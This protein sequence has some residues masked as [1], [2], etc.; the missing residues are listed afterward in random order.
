MGHFKI[1]HE[2]GPK[3][4]S[5]G[6]HIIWSEKSQEFWGKLNYFDANLIIW[7]QIYV[8]IYTFFL[9]LK[10]NQKNVRTFLVNIFQA[11]VVGGLVCRRMKRSQFNGLWLN[12]IPGR[13]IFWCYSFGVI[14]L[15]L[16]V[17]YSIIKLLKSVVYCYIILRK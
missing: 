1:N 8:Y 10:K 4:K 15:L 3:Y 9:Y 7:R 6:V 16:F 5:S 17:C 2:F 11:V 13:Y 14:L 12:A